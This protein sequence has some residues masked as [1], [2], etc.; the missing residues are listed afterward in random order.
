MRRTGSPSAQLSSAQ[1]CQT[2]AAALCWALKLAGGPGRRSPHIPI[3]L[4]P[5]PGAGDPEGGCCALTAGEG[6][7]VPDRFVLVAGRVFLQLAQDFL[8]SCLRGSNQR[9][10]GSLGGFV[11]VLLSA[12]GFF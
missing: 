11:Y 5:L 8:H 4:L 9:L 2:P 10:S 1:A 7:G 12:G 6:A 3:P